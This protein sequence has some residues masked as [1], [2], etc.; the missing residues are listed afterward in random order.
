MMVSGEY[1]APK[2]TPPGEFGTGKRSFCN[3]APGE[4]RASGRRDYRRKRKA[5]RLVQKASRRRSR[6]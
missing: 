5:R 1:G 2:I 6:C 4:A 3:R